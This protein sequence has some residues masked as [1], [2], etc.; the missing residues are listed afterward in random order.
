MKL[1]FTNILKSPKLTKAVD[2]LKVPLEVCHPAKYY[3]IVVFCQFQ[4]LTYIWLI[5]TWSNPPLKSAGD[6]PKIMSN[7]IIRVEPKNVGFLS[8][9]CFVFQL[10]ASSRD[11]HIK[12]LG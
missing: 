1:L 12:Y 2:L 9:F 7:R 6:F 4:S 8:L 5:L 11:Y 3:T 10:Q